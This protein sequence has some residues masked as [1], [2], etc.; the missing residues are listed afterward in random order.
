MPYLIVPFKAFDHR[1]HL[2][3]EYR[4]K[5][6]TIQSKPRNLNKAFALCVSAY[7]LA[8]LVAIAGGYML[9]ELHP[10]II[11]LVADVSARLV[12]YTFSRIFHNASFY[13]AYWSVA[14]LAIALYWMIGTSSEIVVI[15]RQIIVISLVFVWGLRLTYNWASQWQGLKHE[16]WRYTN[17]R[18]KAKGRFW[19]VDLVGIEMM[20]TMIVFL[21]CLPLY[22]ILAVGG[23]PIGVLDVIA[24]ILTTSAIVI[25]AIADKQLGRF[26]RER[27][28]S[29]EIMAK[30]LWA[31]SRHP[32]YFGE[33]AF[34]WGLFIFA[35]AADS[36]YWWTII[37]P[38]SI[39]ILFSV[40]SI[41]MMERRSLERRPGYDEHRKKISILIPWFP[42]E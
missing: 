13:D 26:R 36:G 2:T 1:K 21:A 32:N 27:P 9:R 10:I 24:V 40:V 28:E 20:P 25:E 39:T 16:D 35:L 31:Y 12:V 33:V 17:L 38:V 14:P 6:E 22:P 19:L 3:V 42:K 5:M 4:S 41:P 37:G 11:V 8:L 7:L 30:G 34:W 18:K 15:A 29:G 23:N